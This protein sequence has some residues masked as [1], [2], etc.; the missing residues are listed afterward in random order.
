ML[1]SLF[2]LILFA[3]LVALAIIGFL[4][5]YEQEKNYTYKEENEN[6][7]IEIY[8]PKK[9]TRRNRCKAKTFSGLL[10]KKKAKYGHYCHI[11]KELNKKT[12]DKPKEVWENP[13]E[14]AGLKT[15]KMC[16]AETPSGSCEYLAIQRSN[17]CSHHHE[18]KR[19]G[20]TTQKEYAEMVRLLYDA[21]ESQTVV[22]FTYHR[23]T[24][25]GKRRDIIPEEITQYDNGTIMIRGNCLLRKAERNFNL[26]FMRTLTKGKLWGPK[27]DYKE[28]KEKSTREKISLE[29]IRTEWEKSRI[30]S[31]RLTK[32]KKES[33]SEHTYDIGFFKKRYN[34]KRYKF[35]DRKIDGL[36]ASNAL[37]VVSG[38]PFLC[39]SPVT[40]AIFSWV[41]RNS[42][43]TKGSY[44]KDIKNEIE[45]YLSE[46]ISYKYI[47][48]FIL[49]LYGNTN[50]DIAPAEEEKRKTKASF[51]YSKK[52]LRRIVLV[53]KGISPQE[54]TLEFKKSA[55]FKKSLLLLETLEKK[56][57]FLSDYKLRT[58]EKCRLI[59][60]ENKWFRTYSRRGNVFY[61]KL[62]KICD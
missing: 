31:E 10:C 26:T 25:P 18:M 45:A 35:S 36:T 56:I 47:S 60:V 6:K 3:F 7:I 52:M 2:L 38:L 19:V 5:G 37:E 8:K 62:C 28:I 23:G 32:K 43:K 50:F 29:E 34:P 44:R 57:G 22:G 40:A 21:I 11:H 4:E 13:D 59:G 16:M 53:R 27:E 33:I 12:I 54:M 15:P 46:R 41:H 9:K 55:D 48:N 30:K 24:S 42:K 1:L 14:F 17:Y 49:Q 20:L 58:C 51:K 39:F 61:K